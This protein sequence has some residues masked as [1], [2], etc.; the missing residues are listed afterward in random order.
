MSIGAWMRG[1]TLNYTLYLNA[2]SRSSLL[3]LQ[4]KSSRVREIKGKLWKEEVKCESCILHC[5]KRNEG[6]KTSSK[7]QYV[8]RVGNF[9]DAGHSYHGALQILKMYLQLY[10]LS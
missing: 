6:F 3:L 8:A 5:E 1:T 4:E 7:V 9:I 10:L 2:V